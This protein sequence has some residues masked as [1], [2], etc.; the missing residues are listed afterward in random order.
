MDRNDFIFFIALFAFGI[1]FIAVALALGGCTGRG[2]EAHVV[3][4]GE[5]EY[6]VTIEDGAVSAIAPVEGQR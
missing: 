2:P 1:A 4:D 3:Y 6:A 5:R